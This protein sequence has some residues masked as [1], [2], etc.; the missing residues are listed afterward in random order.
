MIECI[1]KEQCTGCKMCEDICPKGAISFE[2][3]DQGFWYPKVSD[4]C[5][6][7]GLCVKKCPS[8]NKHLQNEE[9]PKVYSAWS[10]NDNVRISSTSGGIFWEIASK[11]IMQG[12]VVVGSRYCDDWKSAKHVIVKNLDELS[13]IKGSKY[14]QSDTEGIYSK[15]RKELEAGNKVL[16]CGTPCQI[17]AIKAFLGREYKKL[18]CMDFICRSINSPKAFRAYID[19]LEKEYNSE[20]VEVHLKNKKNGWQ[21]LA[22]QVCFKN[23]EESIRDKNEDWWVKGFIYNDLYTR[24]SCYHC[25]Y[26]VLPRLNSDITIGDFWGIQ[27][28]KNIDMFKGI[29]VVLLNTQKG[30]EIFNDNKN[31]FIFN[32]HNIDEVLSG[33]PALLKNL[34]NY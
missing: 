20:V 7:C 5:I 18:Y 3:D 9:L 21:S 32:K 31:A 1:K 6:E 15:V 2:T 13:M 12:G 23:G 10:K 33:N 11:F 16:F 34:S 30:K 19:E 4:L 17:S 22:S 24:E 29:S 28:Q 27:N 14:F 25:Q 8:L 26:K